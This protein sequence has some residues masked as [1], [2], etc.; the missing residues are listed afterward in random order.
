MAAITRARS[1]ELTK[2]APDNVAETVAMLTRA[3]FATSFIVAINLVPP[4]LM[5]A[6]GLAQNAIAIP[7]RFHLEEI[8]LDRAPAVISPAMM[9]KNGD[10]ILPLVTSA[11]H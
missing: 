1:S 10:P 11:P 3:A 8:A 5:L 6:L 7:R 2:E 4:T 9:G